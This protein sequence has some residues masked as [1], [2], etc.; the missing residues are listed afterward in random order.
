LFFVGIIEQNF[1]LHHRTSTNSY[2]PQLYALKGWK[3]SL[4]REHLLLHHQYHLPKKVQQKAQSAKSQ[5]IRTKKE[6]ISGLSHIIS[7]CI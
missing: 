2:L 3:K 1:Q 5:P 4:K 6:E 7:W